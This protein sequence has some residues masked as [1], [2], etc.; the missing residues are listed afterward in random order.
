MKR[1]SLKIAGLTLAALFGCFGFAAC[2]GVNIPG[3]GGETEH[4]HV[5]GEWEVVD[6]PTC[7]SQGKQYRVCEDCDY[8]ETETIDALGHKEV[9]V[10]VEKE[11]TCTEQGL[12]VVACEREGCTYSGEV[13]IPALG[14]EMGH[15][16]YNE[17][18]TCTQ[19]GTETSYCQHEG[20]KEFVT[21][22]VLDTAVGHS[23]SYEVQDEAYL[24]S[25][26]NCVDGA[27]Y[28]KSCVCGE[29]SEETFV[30]GTGYGHTYDQKVVADEYLSLEAT[31]T[32]GAVY[33]ESCLCGEKSV[34]T[35][36]YGEALG[37]SY[38]DGVCVGCG[39]NETTVVL[40]SNMT[41][42]LV[43]TPGASYTII[44]Y[45]EVVN[46]NGKITSVKLYDHK[47][48]L[49]DSMV[50]D[51]NWNSSKD[52]FMNDNIY[53]CVY[54]INAA[55]IQEYAFIAV[56]VGEKEYS[57]EEAL[58]RTIERISDEQISKME[59]VD[60]IFN[61][62]I[63]EEEKFETMNMTER[64]Q[65]AEKQLT[66]LTESKYV[67]EESVVY[68]E[69]NA[70]YSFKY[71]SGALGAIDLKDHVS[72]DDILYPSMD[73]PLTAEG[74]PVDAIILWSYDQVWDKKDYAR[75][76]Y[77]TLQTAWT[78]KGINTTVDWE[79]TVADY[80]T[81]KDYELIV[82]STHGSYYE[83][84]VGKAKTD[85]IPALVLSEKVSAEKDLAYAND[86]KMQRIGKISWKG[87]TMY[88]ILPAFWSYYYGGGQLDGSFIVSES[89]EFMGAKDDVNKKMAQALL[90]VAAVSVVGFHNRVMANYGRNFMATYVDAMIS[91]YT[92]KEAFDYA[93]SICGKNDN[94]DD[95]NSHGAVAYPILCGA[96]D[97]TLISTSLE[98]GSFEDPITFKG[99]SIAGDVRL[100]TKLG[101]I[102]PVHGTKMAIL[103]TGVGS[104]TSGYLDATEG[105]VL[106]QSFK[107]KAGQT[108]FSFSYDVVSEEPMKYVGSQY[109]DK[110]YVEI[111]LE[112]GT[113]IK[114][115]E[116]SVNK[117][118]WYYIN[119]VDFEGGDVN[120][121]YHTKWK[122]VSFDLS[123]YANQMITVR[124]VT[125]D[126]GDSQFDTVGLIDNVRLS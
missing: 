29:A 81:L 20:C 60:E 93:K 120:D 8:Q 78:E 56:A 58:V 42:I 23:F 28:Y 108:T 11:A 85:K 122:D 21:N 49:L 59:E 89:E 53:T 124:F 80:K 43:E 17:D 65:E 26:Q 40:T 91:G 10:S 101:D 27:V 119:G 62:S 31:C 51:G 106:S 15:P 102:A 114:L 110:F 100:L 84:R 37:H 107:L 99:W 55:E 6:E 125:Y 95:R 38:E 92:T 109:D 88:A 9:D 83:Y 57:S 118:T 115:V 63:F 44:F 71:E 76:Y 47:G 111:V 97:A 77:E 16:I 103:T 72:T 41:D 68:D 18:A 5:M 86:L 4:E 22:E 82:F 104:G 3:L 30:V 67:E 90:D 25:E 14:H 116:E 66:T 2:E 34:S 45:A 70:I 113:V 126:V 69:V 117:S 112:D 54:T 61:E 48:N 98:N 52:E 19:N 32:A 39:E 46:G 1:R 7:T 73:A 12:K 79:V 50:D 64:K 24:K 13:E 35:F 36:V 74:K 121:A 87:G 105:S 96:E 33:F 123:A 75:S 94:F